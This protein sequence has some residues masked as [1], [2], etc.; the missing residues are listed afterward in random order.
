MLSK[1]IKNSKYAYYKSMTQKNI[2]DPKKLWKVI[3]EATSDQVCE[4]EI[5]CI[6]NQK[7][8]EITDKNLMANEFNSYFCNIGKHLANKI[9]RCTQN[10]AMKEK[11]SANS[12][13]LSPVSSEDIIR[14]ISNLKNDIKGGE[15]AI[16]SNIIKK[17]KD[18][19][20]IPLK[21]ITNL[22]F[23]SG[24]FPNILKITTIIPLYKQGD[25]KSMN[26]YRPIALT[27]TIS[28]IIE[29]CLKSKLITF[30]EEHHLLNANQFAFRR[31]SNT[32]KALV[33]VTEG[34]LK[35]LD[36]GKKVMGIFLDLRKAFDTVEH[37]TLLKRLEKAG[38]RGIPNNL[39]RSYLTNRNQTTLVSGQESDA[40]QVNFGVP[41]GTVLSTLLFNIYIN[42]IMDL[43]DDE[44][45]KI[46][47]FADDTSVLISEDTWEATIAKAENT[48]QKLK[49]WLD[50][51]LLSLNVEKTNFVAFALSA[52]N[53]PN[54][55]SIKIHESKC[56]R[57]RQCK[58]GMAIKRKTSLKYLGV[59]LDEKLTWKEHVEY[60]TTKLRKLIY[61]FYELRNMV[62]FKT[63]KT[64]YHAL[65]ES[66]LNYGL[67]VWGAAG[68]II[69]TKLQVTQKWIIKI[70]LF[71]KRRYP[72][73]R[74]YNESKIL[75]IEQLHL[76]SV[77]RFMIKNNDY[78][79]NLKHCQNTRNVTRGMVE[80]QN[81][82]HKSCQKHICCVGPKIYND[83]PDRFKLKDYHRIKK[84]LTE[85]IVESKYKITYVI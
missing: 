15:D 64:I 39:I 30:L 1:L 17:Y 46:Y 42:D 37:Q 22:V 18:N 56:N 13:F 31:N 23:S 16:S 11:R 78:K 34:I 57:N 69:L 7:N 26:N 60:V 20:S 35:N 28:K 27:S 65:A 81:P 33:K 36:R 82:K 38:I 14:E 58:C 32:D 40:L 83:L 77:I 61:K 72:S 49:N 75:N 80:L 45:I 51:S 79:V 24:I 62:P 25:K 73:D 21:H 6:T 48:L 12:F 68:S 54:L 52:R 3:R 10:R 70:M 63:L 59:I 85:W 19:L 55:E 50:D 41:Q 9:S 66:L 47:C 84:T 5:K 74:V 8:I 67:V 43:F 44:N 71:K 76:K 29:K 53:L 2:N 4:S